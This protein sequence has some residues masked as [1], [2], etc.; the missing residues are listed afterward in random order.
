MPSDFE[1][2]AKV[3]R[4][5][6]NLDRPEAA[7]RQ[8]GT[9]MVAE[10][11]QAFRDQKFGD[12]EWDARSSVN[13]FGIIAD[14]HAGRKPP[15]RRFER[16]PALRDTGRLAQSI[17]HRMVSKDVVE[18]GSNLPYAGVHNVGGQVTSMPI[19]DQVRDLL[20]RWLKGPGK[21]HRGRLGWLLNKKFR[22]QTL[23]QRVPARRIVGITKNTIEDV[24]E[25]VGVRIMETR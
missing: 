13:V 18:V 21:P 5:E 10:S 15:D 20:A 23:K 25:A 4:W 12:E 19:T 16:R 6:R 24:R 8:V 11:Q 1:K 3:E 7:L 9:L 2:G 17:A 22:G 14:F